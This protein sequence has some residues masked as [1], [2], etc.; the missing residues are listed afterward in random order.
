MVLNKMGCALGKFRFYS[1]EAVT[2]AKN[3]IP[4]ASENA[5]QRNFQRR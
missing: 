2:D 3:Q 1:K 5:G 4:C